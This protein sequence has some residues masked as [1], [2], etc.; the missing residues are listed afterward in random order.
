MEIVLLWLDDLDDLLF[1]LALLWERVRR[2]LLQI[3]LG[4]AFGLIGVDALA[5][6]TRFAPGFASVAASCVAAWLVGAM[7]RVYYYRGSRQSLNPA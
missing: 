2:V 3:G 6:G 4:A 5:I 1:S 7:L